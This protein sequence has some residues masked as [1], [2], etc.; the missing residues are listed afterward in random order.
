MLGLFLI[1]KI[2][3]KYG[4]SSSS[5]VVTLKCLLIFSKLYLLEIKEIGHLSVR[6]MSA[7]CHLSVTEVSE[8]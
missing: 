3:S 7:K 8:K 5:T 1:N 2:F 6:K 4:K